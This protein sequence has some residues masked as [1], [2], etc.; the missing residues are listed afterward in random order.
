MKDQ[1]AEVVEHTCVC[2]LMAVSYIV[3]DLPCHVP[4]E[5]LDDIARDAGKVSLLELTVYPQRISKTARDTGETTT[6]K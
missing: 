3:I 5:G 6:A 4:R 2:H 1:T